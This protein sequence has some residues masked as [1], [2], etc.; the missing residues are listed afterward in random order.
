MPYVLRRAGFYLFT[1]WAAITVNFI[2]PRLMPGNPVEALVVK[3]KGRL[4]PAA[5]KAI[6]A[7]F[8]IGHMSLWASY[9]QYWRDLLAGNLGVSFSFFPYTVRWEIGSSIFWTLGLVGISTVISFV[10]GTLIGIFA[11]WKRGSWLDHVLPAATFF[12]AVPY[13]WLGLLIL[14]VF[15]QVLGIFPVSGAYSTTLT[16]GL[17]LPFIGSIALYGLLP[18]STLVLS[19]VAG[20]IIQ[21][22]NMMITTLGEDFV[23][24]AEAKGLPR[25]RIIFTYAARNAVLPSVASFALSLGFVVSGALLTEVVFDYP[26]IGYALYQ[27]VRNL[28]YPLMQGI[29]LMIT[30]CVLAANLLADV[31]Y[32]VLD[33]RT[34][35][36]RPA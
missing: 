29:F 14:F 25:R 36:G 23:L 17:S 32:A 9:V 13:F 12:T 16:P 10:I 5:V 28:D 11:G 1:A 34:R 19:S 35:G 27:A 30:L 22:R 24:M 7:L 20:W 18:V 33:P 2:I 8:G 31:L 15:G 3:F 26:G 4:S 6:S 21:M